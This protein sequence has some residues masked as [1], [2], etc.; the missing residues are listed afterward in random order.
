MKYPIETA[1]IQSGRNYATANMHTKA[2]YFY[3][4]SY[5]SNDKLNSRLNCALIINS[6]LIGSYWFSIFNREN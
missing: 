3:A 2:T 6:S 1:Q 5:Q 4:E